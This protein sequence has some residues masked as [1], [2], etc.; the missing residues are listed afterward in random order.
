MAWIK[1]TAPFSHKPTPAVTVDYKP[2][3]YQVTSACATL[4]V[5]AGK[6]VR[7][8]KTN[9]NEEPVEE[10]VAERLDAISDR[11]DRV[12]DRTRRQSDE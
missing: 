8:R 11:I 12:L 1:V 9:K 4:A 5:A 2:G 3:V 7:L 6:A 10:A